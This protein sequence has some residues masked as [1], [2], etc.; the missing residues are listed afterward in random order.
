MTSTATNHRSSELDDL[1]LHLQ[2]LVLVRN[3][4]RHTGAEAKELNLYS[5][6]IDRARDRLAQFVRHE[7]QSPGA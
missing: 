5:T 1:V 4:R 7:N 6:E 2:G 3:L